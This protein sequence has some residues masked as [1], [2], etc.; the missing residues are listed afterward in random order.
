MVKYKCDVYV[1]TDLI[2]DE[3]MGVYKLK[4]GAYFT[5][6]QFIL[7]EISSENKSEMLEELDSSFLCNDTYCLIDNIISIEKVK[8]FQ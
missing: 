1:L 2:H 7:N 5:A 4:F 3:I 6:K 8:L